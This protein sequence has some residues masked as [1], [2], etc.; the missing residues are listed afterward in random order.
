M[1]T[2]GIGKR[3]SV[4]SKIIMENTIFESFLS[5]CSLSAKISWNK[6]FIEIRNKMPIKICLR[7]I[8]FLTSLKQKQVAFVGLQMCNF[9]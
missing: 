2:N 7:E 8:F 1:E 5:K 6:T 3:D 4:L 9:G